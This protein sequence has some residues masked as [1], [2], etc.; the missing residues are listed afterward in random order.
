MRRDRSLSIRIAGDRS[1][2]SHSRAQRLKIARK[3]ARVRLM[4]P[5]AH[6]SARFA[7]VM[8]S[9]NARFI[10]SN[11]LP[12]KNRSSQR[13]FNLSS[14]CVALWLCSWSQRTA[15]SCQ[16]RFG[17]SPS[18]CSWTS[19][20]SVDSFQPLFPPLCPHLMHSTGAV[21]RRRRK[22]LCGRVFL[23][24]HFAATEREALGATI[25][26]DPRGLYPPIFRD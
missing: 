15:A 21:C 8:V 6:P 24:F 2:H 3:S 14:S 13:S 25:C 9:I 1:V 4:V 18:R 7:S 22:K 23:L 11:S 12:A 16:I 19:P 20:V 17:R 5:F 10:V 26:I